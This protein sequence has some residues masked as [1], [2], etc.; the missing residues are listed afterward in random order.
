M[1]AHNAMDNELGEKR[2]SVYE[3]C[4]K[5]NWKRMNYEYN[6]DKESSMRDLRCGHQRWSWPG[7]FRDRFAHVLRRRGFGNVHIRPGIRRESP[8]EFPVWTRTSAG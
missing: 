6:E 1:K 5:K 3:G 8:I 7:D 4:V 2:E